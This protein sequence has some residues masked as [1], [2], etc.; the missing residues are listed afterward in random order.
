MNNE[1][2]E[3]ENMINRKLDALKEAVLSLILR[4]APVLGGVIDAERA[5]RLEGAW[6][7]EDDE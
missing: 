7:R 2:T 1:K 6:K 4:G 3:A 5:E